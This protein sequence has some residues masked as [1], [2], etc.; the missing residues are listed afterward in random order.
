MRITTSRFGAIDLTEDDLIHFPEGLLGFNDLRHFVLLDDPSDEI[1][2]WLQSCENGEI[3]FPVLEPELFVQA[4][5]PVL[6]KSDLE[7]LQMQAA[8]P[9]RF[10]SIVTIPTDPTLMTANLKAPI[11]INLKKRVARQ[12]VLQDNN[13]AI[14]EPIFSKLQQRVVSNPQV[15]IKSQLTDLEE[16]GVRLPDANNT[17]EITKR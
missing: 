4:Y 9:V 6:S 1:F 7:I 13:L 5:K 8:D 17:P 12:C 15:T 16:L 14:R 10:F 11:V 3:A 2:A